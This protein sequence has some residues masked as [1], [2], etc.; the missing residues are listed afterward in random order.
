[1]ANN[2]RY[3]KNVQLSEESHIKNLLM[4]ISR[5]ACE[6]QLQKLIIKQNT[7]CF[8]TSIFDN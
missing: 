8:V 6:L 1:M 4:N 7:L 5:E 2:H 3:E